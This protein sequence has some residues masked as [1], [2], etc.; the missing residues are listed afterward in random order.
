MKVRN[1][2]AALT[3]LC[4]FI[5]AAGYNLLSAS[6]APF[7]K[8]LGSPGPHYTKSDLPQLAVGLAFSK[9]G[10]HLVAWQ[11]SGKI[12]S[13]DLGSGK[14]REIG[15][16]KSVFAYCTANDLILR[17]GEGGT[18]VVET[19][20]GK[21][22]TQMELGE[23]AHAAW[24]NDCS[25]FALAPKDKNL[26]ELWDGQQIYQIGSATTSMPVRNGIALS[27]DGTQVAAAMGNYS[28]AM[29]HRTVIETF[30]PQ[31]DGKLARRSIY[32]AAN[33]M[34]GMWKMVFSPDSARLFV[35]SQIAGKSGLRGFE[36]DSGSEDWHQKGFESYWVRALAISPDGAHLISGDEKG[37]LRIWGAASGKRLN[38]YKTGL[39]VQ[40][41]AFSADGR[42]LAVALCD[43]TIGILSTAAALGAGS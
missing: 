8:V 11:K 7:S 38:S 27:A 42:R 24:S 33:S 5:A 29:G 4:L 30:S 10:R 15:Q 17:A 12:V 39:V 13:W 36:A 25:K 1:L 2:F 32:N 22:I 21:P 20:G 35:G 37:N 34:L 19:L 28:D 31:L 3:V 26:L 9:D 18:L 43:G 23:M 6:N 41:V 16:S 40:S 14:S